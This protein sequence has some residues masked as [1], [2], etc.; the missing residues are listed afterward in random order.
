MKLYYISQNNYL[1][2]TQ[3][4]TKCLYNIIGKLHHFFFAYY[5]IQ[6]YQS[7]VGILIEQVRRYFEP[8]VHRCRPALEK[9]FSCQTGLTDFIKM[10]KKGLYDKL[11]TGT[12]L[13]D[14][15]KG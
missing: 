8:C 11:Y 13:T 3:T 6:E 7:V 1:H 4:L 12:V 5:I 15:S 14:L 2:K 9:G 10:C